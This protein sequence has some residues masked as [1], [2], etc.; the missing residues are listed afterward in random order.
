MPGLV[1][2]SDTGTALAI[3]SLAAGLSAF[4][5][6]VSVGV[7]GGTDNMT[8]IIWNFVV[9]YLLTAVLSRTLASEN[10]PANQNWKTTSTTENVVQATTSVR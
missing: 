4:G 2:I 1:R 8:I 9:M 5:G 3:Y 6:P 7:L 10:D